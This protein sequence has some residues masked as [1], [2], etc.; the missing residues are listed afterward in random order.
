MAKDQLLFKGLALGA[1]VVGG[2]AIAQ[3]VNARFKRQKDEQEIAEIIETVENFSGARGR[4]G[5]CW[6]ENADGTY[7]EM[8]PCPDKTTRS[9]FRGG[10]IFKQPRRG[11]TVWC[12][13]RSNPQEAVP[14]GGQY[15]SKT[16][17]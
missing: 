14:C 13:H 17:F 2:V 12:Q 7:T 1:M 16:P 11:E 9:S 6:I 5:G 15:A 8:N 4:S 3:A 10:N